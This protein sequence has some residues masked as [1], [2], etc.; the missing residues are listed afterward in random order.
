MGFLQLYGRDGQRHMIHAS[1]H[2]AYDYIEAQDMLSWQCSWQTRDLLS[3]N[4]NRLCCLSPIVLS[5]Q[6]TW[7]DNFYNSMFHDHLTCGTNICGG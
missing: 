3:D 6:Q 2:G 7:Q 1:F 4:S 5:P